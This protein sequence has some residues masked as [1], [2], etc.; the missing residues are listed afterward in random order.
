MTWFDRVYGPGAVLE[1]YEI[2]FSKSG[3]P[4]KR[5]RVL[6][7]T[8]GV[9]EL[10]ET[11]KSDM[12]SYIQS[13]AD[14]VDINKILERYKSGDLTVLDRQKGAYLDI[15]NAPKNLAEMYS[16][17]RNCQTFFDGLPL[18]VRKE[19]DFN[20]AKFVEDI[21]SEKFVKLMSPAPAPEEKKEEVNPD[22]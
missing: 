4:F 3:S 5:E 21:G 20:A 18:E 6:K 13:H 1:N 16:F 11:G 22:A 9:Q 17:I 10:V 7:D 2:K 15:A 12:Y 19:Y 14:S 8:K